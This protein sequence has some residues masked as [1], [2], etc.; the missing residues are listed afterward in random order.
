MSQSIQG[1]APTLTVVDG[2][3]TCLSTEVARHFGKQHRNV[4]RAI[5]NL[6]GQLD[7][8]YALNFERIQIDVDLGL[9][10]TR[11]DSAYRLSKDG[12]TLLAMG[13][14]GKK[15]LRFKL[16]YIDAFNRMEAKLQQS[17]YALAKLPQ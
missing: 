17:Q 9:G 1:I 10:R 7:K 4:L 2:I 5:E 6:Q 12:F 16:A 3:P 11:K 14:T 15:A 13:F 8:T